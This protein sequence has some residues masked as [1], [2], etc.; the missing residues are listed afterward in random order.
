[1]VT[2]DLYILLYA[3]VDIGNL[4]FPI[5]EVSIALFHLMFEQ[6]KQNILPIDEFLWS[7]RDNL[8]TINIVA[9]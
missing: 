8:R 4:I 2:K 5:F 3:M 6:Q 7:K 9:T 1:M